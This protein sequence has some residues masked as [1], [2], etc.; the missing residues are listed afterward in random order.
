MPSKKLPVSA[1][2]H[3]MPQVVGTEFLEEPALCAE[4]KVTPRTLA[5]WRTQRI[6]PPRVTVGRTILYRREAVLEWLASREEQLV[7]PRKRA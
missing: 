1:E 2:T 7:K 6:G 3:S 4:L 5:R